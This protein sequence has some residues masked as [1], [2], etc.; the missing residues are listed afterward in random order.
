[1]NEWIDLHHIEWKNKWSESN[2]VRVVVVHI[3][4]GVNLL[5]PYACDIDTYQINQSKLIIDWERYM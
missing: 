3:C 4:V 2:S 5:A 1:M